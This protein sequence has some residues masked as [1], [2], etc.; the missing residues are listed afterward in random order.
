MA[1]C[2]PD[3]LCTIL[4]CWLWSFLQVI[5]LS[6]HGILSV[7]KDN[8]ALVFSR[9][10]RDFETDFNE[11]VC[12]QRGKFCFFV[13]SRQ[14]ICFWKLLLGRCIVLM[15]FTAFLEKKS[16]RR[17]FEDVLVVGQSI[18]IRLTMGYL[19]YYYLVL[20]IFAWNSITLMTSMQSI[21]HNR[22]WPSVK[23]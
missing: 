5:S 12:T 13:V 4:S 14:R 19:L 16:M 1:I 18:S 20:R 6:C 21:T 23:H 8:T 7:D 2:W 9:I 22:F 3:C 17:L 11:M 10:W 15:R